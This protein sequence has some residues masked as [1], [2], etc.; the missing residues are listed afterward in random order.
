MWFPS[1]RV[2][3][4]H[5]RRPLFQPAVWQLYCLPIVAAGLLASAG[6]DQLP[7]IVDGATARQAGPASAP[8]PPPPLRADSLLVD[9]PPREADKIRIASYNIQVFGVTKEAK[10][11]V[12][13]VLAEIVR[14]FDVVAIQEIRSTDQGLMD[15]F[16]A[17]V[18][19]RGHS[20]HYVLGPRL[21]RTVSK[22]QYAFVYDTTRLTVDP[23]SVHTVDD[24]DDLLH[25]EPLIARFV[26]NQLPAGQGF[27]FTLINM[28]TDPDEAEDE[29][30]VLDDV[31]LSARADGRY[32]EDVILLGDLNVNH[33]RLGQLGGVPGIRCTVMGEPTNTAGTK[34]YDNLVF[35]PGATSEYTGR[36]G[37]LDV[38]RAFRLTDEQAKEVSDHRPVWAEFSIYE[39]RATSLAARPR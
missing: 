5:C 22:E 30:N 12:M 29:V 23:R 36:A 32:E 15:R 16:V 37:V 1:I 9:L 10:T 2:S 14:Q 27:S 17:L 18:N 19:Q 34:S 13:H 7:A 21:G 28:H 24:P 4:R 31:F 8:G 39:R 6:C 33:E 26:F 3:T 38:Q 20:Y 35:D 11:Q 25:R